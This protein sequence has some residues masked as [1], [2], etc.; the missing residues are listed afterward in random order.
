MQEK[1][2]SRF[3]LAEG[4]YNANEIIEEAKRQSIG[5]KVATIYHHLKNGTFPNTW[6]LLQKHPYIIHAS[7]YKNNR[8]VTTP[9][10]ADRWNPNA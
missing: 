6:L 1:I 2:L 9:Y 7:N 4:D 5:L 10:S 8:G 3:I